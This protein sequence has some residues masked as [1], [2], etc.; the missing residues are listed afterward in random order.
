MK[1]F[2]GNRPIKYY[3]QHDLKRYVASILDR[4]AGVNSAEDIIVQAIIDRVSNL[5][6]QAGAAVD[7]A[8]VLSKLWFFRTAAPVR[9][10]NISAVLIL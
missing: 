2:R 1:N 10:K 8:I 3:R 9:L 6:P 4:S 7:K 5:Q